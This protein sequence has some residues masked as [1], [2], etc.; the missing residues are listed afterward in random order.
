MELK[1][2]ISILAALVALALPSIAVAAQTPDPV[3]PRT[4][5]TLFLKDGVHFNTGITEAVKTISCAG[6]GQ[7]HRGKYTT[8]HCVAETKKHPFL[9]MLVKTHHGANPKWVYWHWVIYESGP[10]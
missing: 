8:F 6:L 9:P 4:V 1:T 10:A 5:E 3:K 7:S 2:R